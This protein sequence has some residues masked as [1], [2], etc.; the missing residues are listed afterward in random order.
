MPPA[1]L[2]GLETVFSNILSVAIGIG[3]IVLFIMIVMGG[4]SYISAGGDP[5]KAAAAKNTITYAIF[6]VVLLALA[7]LFL[8]LI[9]GFTGV[10]EILNFQVSQ[11]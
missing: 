1:E 3:G 8:R 4:F 2:N 9:A 5:Q 6:G 11:P 10:N 7:Y